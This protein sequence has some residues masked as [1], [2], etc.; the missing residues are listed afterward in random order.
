MATKTVT[1]GNLLRSNE[2]CASPVA[3][4]TFSSGD[5]VKIPAEDKNL[6]ILIQPSAT[7][8]IVISKGNGY[9]GVAD[10][11]LA[12]TADKDNWV[13]LDTAAF[14]NV[15]GA[16]KGFIIMAPAVAGSLSLINAL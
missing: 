13:Q 3:A 16:N 8:N 4:T 6:V 7:G 1:K 15:S 12:V 2:V 14:G 9:A 10:L 5:T 11:T